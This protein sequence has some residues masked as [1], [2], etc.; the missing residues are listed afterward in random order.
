VLKYPNI[1]LFN[2][3]S[4]APLK[5]LALKIRPHSYDPAFFPST[6]TRCILDCDD[7]FGQDC[8]LHELPSSLMR[9]KLTGRQFSFNPEFL[10]PRITHL[11]LRVKFEVE[12]EEFA[13]LPKTLT[14]LGVFKMGWQRHPHF[15]S[16]HVAAVL[17]NL[18]TFRFSGT[19]ASAMNRYI[20]PNWVLPPRLTR[21]ECTDQFIS[22]ENPKNFWALS[23]LHLPKVQ[24][25]EDLLLDMP[26]TIVSLR[27]RLIRLF[28]I[29]ASKDT[30]LTHLSKRI[31]LN[32]F[33]E[34]VLM[35]KN[36]HGR[37]ISAIQTRICELWALPPNLETISR[38]LRVCDLQM[39]LPIKHD[40]ED[41][42]KIFDEVGLLHIPPSMKNLNAFTFKIPSEHI[43]FLLDRIEESGSVKSLVI[44]EGLAKWAG[45]HFL[46]PLDGFRIHKEIT[47]DF[48]LHLPKGLTKLVISQDIEFRSSETKM[49]VLPHLQE[50]VLRGFTVSVRLAPFLRDSCPSLV[51]LT[52]PFS[53]QFFYD[54]L[55]HFPPN[56]TELRC[57]TASANLDSSFFEY[58]P[59]K[60]VLL[61]IRT[62]CK[63]V[64]SHIPF[65]PQSL[66]SLHLNTRPWLND[67]I[68]A[69]PK[70]LVLFSPS[71]A[72]LRRI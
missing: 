13:I 11:T 16:S 38:K 26:T 41:E 43:C 40:A 17:P 19:F 46:P 25:G 58:L 61:E 24:L 14:Y 66:T 54:C 15:W 68:K 31:L 36:C 37:V 23:H 29:A 49:S 67:E 2:C 30:S 35:Q 55:E 70:G 28:G 64:S 8:P 5:F 53:H 57:V 34:W 52:I 44:P 56:L 59:R 3:F 62:Y 72:N 12:A 60:L 1:D 9:I 20:D 51:K 21:L 32:H 18:E 27:V 63:L 45:S 10:P 39:R 69:L 42:A 22:Q 48:L 50:L 33:E 7:D 4:T 65:L 6:L 47:Y 71:K